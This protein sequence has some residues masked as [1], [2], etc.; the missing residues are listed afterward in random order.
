MGPCC[1]DLSMQK[2]YKGIHLALEFVQL[3]GNRNRCMI[4]QIVAGWSD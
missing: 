3:V 2:G 1:A 4:E